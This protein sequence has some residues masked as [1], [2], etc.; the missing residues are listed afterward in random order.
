MESNLC[1]ETIM[2]G[3]MQGITNE[4]TQSVLQVENMMEEFELFKMFCKM[5]QSQSGGN[6]GILANN[7]IVNQLTE[8]YPINQE[9]EFEMEVN[10]EMKIIGNGS[11]YEIKNRNKWG[12]AYYF[13]DDNKDKKRKV[14]T[15]NS[16][17]DAR[18][19]LD[20]LL[21][22]KGGVGKVNVVETGRVSYDEEH[23]LKNYAEYYLGRVKPKVKKSTY[24]GYLSTNKIVTRHIGELYLEELT[25][26][27][28]EQMFK[29]IG[30]QE[31]HIGER[32][33]CGIYDWLK[34]I[35]KDAKRKG[36]V[37]ENLM[38]L[39]SKRDAKNLVVKRKEQYRKDVEVISEKNMKLLKQHMRNDVY[40]TMI[41][42]IEHTG[43]RAGE[44]GALQWGNIDFANK[45]IYIEYNL[46][47]R[48]DRTCIPIGTSK[49][50]LTSPKTDSSRRTIHMNETAYKLL[51]AWKQR[52]ESIEMKNKKMKNGTQNLVFTNKNGNPVIPGMIL[53][54]IKD[55]CKK[56]GIY[57]V[58]K[59]GNKYLPHTH[60]I[61]HLT[62]TRLLRAGT[63]VMVVGEILGHTDIQT[64][65]IYITILDEDK[66]NAMKSLD[67]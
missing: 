6:N 60:M 7:A 48:L 20:K 46:T 62:A 27:D 49:V 45:K 28:I 64:T 36:I 38:E 13:E 52:K 8:R 54:T 53:K 16:E 57:E 42:L 35:L 59:D 44:A 23:K 65:Q 50:G 3:I 31:S 51:G 5:R 26:D 15:F 4:G 10:G 29:R 9:L 30:E 21:N 2:Q 22:K 37:S 12:V 40:R 55:I 63:N 34:R 33:T 17:K 47:T 1:M 24:D 61:R 19:F 41:E 43:M 67:K 25:S 18:R 14:N 11:V 58:D 56:H 32:Y 39:V 66:S